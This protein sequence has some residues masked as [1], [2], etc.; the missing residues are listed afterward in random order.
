MTGLVLVQTRFCN[1]HNIYFQYKCK[2]VIAIYTLK[3]VILYG[4]EGKENFL[5][6]NSMDDLWPKL[7][8]QRMEN[9]I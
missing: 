4:S 6:R 5:K 3:P 8:N 1:R 9:K 2:V 7:C